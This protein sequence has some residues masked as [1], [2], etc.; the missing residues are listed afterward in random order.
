MCLFLL[1]FQSINIPVSKK[2]IFDINIQKEISK[3]YEQVE[4]LKSELLNKTNE[5]AFLTSAIPNIEGCKWDLCWDYHE[6]FEFLGKRAG[7]VKKNNP[8]VRERCDEFIATFEKMKKESETII[9]SYC[10]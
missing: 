3:K 7:F 10:G 6:N 8:N 1:L 9:K 4:T 2:G 5:Y